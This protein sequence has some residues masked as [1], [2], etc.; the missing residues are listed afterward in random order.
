[1]VA[2]VL[3]RKTGG[4]F[5]AP[6]AAGVPPP[7]DRTLDVRARPVWISRREPDG[8][9]RVRELLARLGAAIDDRDRPDERSLCVTTPLGKDTT[10]SAAEEGLDFARTV[11]VDT[12][13]PLERHRTLMV[14]PATSPAWRD[15]ASATFGADGTAVTVIGDS[16]GFVAQRIVAMLV[17]VGCNVAQLG[18]AS[19]EDID[20]AA[21]LGLN[22]PW[23]PLELGDRLGAGRILR[24]L[25]GLHAFYGD[26][27]YRPMAWLR[28]RAML[29][30]SLLVP[31]DAAA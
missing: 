29:G 11:A 25:E 27:R 19:P 9:E 4:G 13:F 21:R 15:A 30:A 20:K 3:G 17:N 2:G 31:N 28:R 24:I 23:G 8:A 26:P 12:L 14:S 22:Y 7:P 5:Y 16:P 1:M 6:P 10:T 18:V